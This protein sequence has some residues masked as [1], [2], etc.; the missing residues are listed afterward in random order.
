[1]DENP[2]YEVFHHN[3]VDLSHAFYAVRVS[4]EHTTVVYEPYL[5]VP[6]SQ[7]V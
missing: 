1:V 7:S 6:I 2:Y 4:P 5:L 3:Y